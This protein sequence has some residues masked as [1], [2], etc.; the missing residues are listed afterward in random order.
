MIAVDALT[1]LRL[2]LSDP[3]NVLQ[4]WTWN[5]TDVTPCSW[6]HVTC[7]NETKVVRV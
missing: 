6:F 1:A 3:K 2:S 4:S 5:A 7:N